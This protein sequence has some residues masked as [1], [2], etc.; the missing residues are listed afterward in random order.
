M[1]TVYAVDISHMEAA[2]YDALYKASSPERKVRADKS[3][4]QDAARC[5]IAAEA[6]LRY[7]VKSHLGISDFT[8]EKNPYGKPRLTGIH[9]FYFNL[10]HSG[11][12]VVLACGATELGIDVETI[13]AEQQKEKLARRFFTP[14]EQSFIFGEETGIDERFYQIWTAKESYLKYLGTGLQKALNSFCV[15]TMEHPNFFFHRLADCAMTLCSEEKEYHVQL[16][17]PEEL[18]QRER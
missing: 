15:R 17:S 12:W 4:N 11:H 10:S 7:A 16:L 5:T 3:R 6:L 9:D 1:I 8:M 2:C 18:L 14:E 13:K